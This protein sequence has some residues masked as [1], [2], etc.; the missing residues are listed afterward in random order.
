MMEKTA[1]RVAILGSINLLRGAV[2]NASLL[3]LHALLGKVEIKVPISVTV[4]NHCHGKMHTSLILSALLS[5]MRKKTEAL[6]ATVWV[7]SLGKD[8]RKKI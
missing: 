4:R 3:I 1:G 5:S 7:F 2:N 6:T 8:R